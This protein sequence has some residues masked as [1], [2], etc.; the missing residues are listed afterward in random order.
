M[1][2]PTTRE[3]REQWITNRAYF[4]WLEEGQPH[5]ESAR[6]Y[7]EAEREYQKTFEEEWRRAQHRAMSSMSID[8]AEGDDPRE[9]IREATMEHFLNEV[10][11]ISFRTV[12]GKPAAGSMIVWLKQDFGFD[13][14]VATLPDNMTPPCSVYVQ[15]YRYIPTKA[16]YVVTPDH[17][18]AGSW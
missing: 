9:V 12:A 15:F 18:V 2:E 7:M 5:G 1:I 3:K 13:W 11:F 6:H 4:K 16:E 10:S 14:R 8:I 17:A